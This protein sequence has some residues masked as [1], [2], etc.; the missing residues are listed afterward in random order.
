[1]LCVELRPHINKQATKFHLPVPVD[2][3]V[4]LT[5]WRLATNVEYQTI[6]ELL[7]LGISTLCTIVN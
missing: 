4:A 5:V 3:Q 7:G 1:M 2:K 6:S